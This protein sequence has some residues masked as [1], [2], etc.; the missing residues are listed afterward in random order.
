MARSA[1]YPEVL[2]RPDLRY[3]PPTIPPSNDGIHS[4]SASISHLPPTAD[5]QYLQRRSSMAMSEQFF[6]RRPNKTLPTVPGSPSGSRR[7]R[8]QRNP[9]SAYI[10]RQSSFDY[11][12]SLD[13]HM[14]MIEVNIITRA[15]SR[16]GSRHIPQ[17]DLPLRHDEPRVPARANSQRAERE[18]PRQLQ[19]SI[20]VDT[21]KEVRP[22][23]AH[24]TGMAISRLKAQPTA[25][26]PLSLGDI[27]SGFGNLESLFGAKKAIAVA[28]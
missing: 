15:T 14:R 27:S 13:E 10:K 6:V 16:P 20:P 11:E 12:Q 1:E 26:R 8:E 25:L 28:S 4:R 22:S 9:Q 3:F 17:A 5:V 7:G 18:D 24:P 23:T 19:S 21:R 2:M